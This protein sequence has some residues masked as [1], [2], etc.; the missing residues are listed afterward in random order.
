MGFVSLSVV[1]ISTFTFVLQAS[2]EATE[3]NMFL[4]ILETVDVLAVMFF[5]LEYVVRLACAP[6]KWR[7]VKTTANLVDF[8]AITP[9]YITLILDQLEDLQIL[10]KAGK[11]IRLV[12]VLRIFR[13][14]KL[15]KHFDRLQSLIITLN[16]AYKDLGL[17]MLLMILAMLFCTF[18]MFSAE[19]DGSEDSMSFSNC[20]WW[21]IMTLT[22]VGSDQGGPQTKIGKFIGSICALLA[23]F[24]ISLPI[25]L[26]VNSFENCYEDYLCRTSI[27]QKKA[28]NLAQQ[29]N[30]IFSRG[31]KSLVDISSNISKP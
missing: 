18:L 5:T 29:R 11:L 3:D 15:V 1:L 17:L 2:Q 21:C 12:R 13:M 9:F 19:N 31:I 27:T 22:T 8:V 25:P 26:V 7:F 20:L 28:K 23:I 6:K 30:E 14:F 24:M 16:K 4:K 10:G